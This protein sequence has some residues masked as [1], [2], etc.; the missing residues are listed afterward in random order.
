MRDLTSVRN[1]VEVQVNR[2]N[3]GIRNLRSLLYDL[4]AKIERLRRQSTY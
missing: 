1:D 3:L 2:L 4:T